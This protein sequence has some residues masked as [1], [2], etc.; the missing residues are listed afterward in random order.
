MLDGLSLQLQSF[1][2]TIHVE[3]QQP[4]NTNTKPVMLKSTAVTPATTAM[5]AMKLPEGRRSSS[6]ASANEVGLLLPLPIPPNEAQL[7]AGK[8]KRSG[9]LV[10]VDDDLVCVTE[11]VWHSSGDIVTDDAAAVWFAGVLPPLKL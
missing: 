2:S 10:V 5:P 3:G 7:V 6:S 9:G 11:D 8:L 1:L 4:T